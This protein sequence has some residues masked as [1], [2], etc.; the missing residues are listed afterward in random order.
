MRHECLLG[1]VLLPGE[2]LTAANHRRKLY[3]PGVSILYHVDD[4]WLL[5]DW[6]CMDRD[7]RRMD[8][9]LFLETELLLLS[10]N[11]HSSR[12]LVFGR[13]TYSS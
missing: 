4:T 7:W 9:N 11:A 12:F 6:R 3:L 5:L 13:T 10:Q 1:R 8:E 2:H